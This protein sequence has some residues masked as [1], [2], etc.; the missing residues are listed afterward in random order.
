ME[1]TDICCQSIS[2]KDG[3]SKVHQRYSD[4]FIFVPEM[5]QV[6]LIAE[7]DGSNLLAEDIENGYVDYIYYEQYELG[8]D[9]PEVDG[10]QILLGEMLRDKY[11]CM[12]ECIPDVLDMAY[13]DRMTG[14]MVL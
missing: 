9:M 11:R 4:I 8:V 1:H 14:Y 13:G 7:G 2:I 6:I 10:G 12:A 5:R 3:D